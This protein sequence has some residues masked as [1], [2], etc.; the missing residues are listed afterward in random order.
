[1]GFLEFKKQFES[2]LEGKIPVELLELHFMAYAFGNGSI[3]YK[4][5]GINYQFIFD[6]RENLL[7]CERSKPHEKY[8]HCNWEELFAQTGLDVSDKQIDLILKA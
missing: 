3:V 2:K 1:M 6:G 7:V 5:K 8:P 4:I